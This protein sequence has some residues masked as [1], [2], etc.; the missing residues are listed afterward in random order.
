MCVTAKE[1]EFEKEGAV[2]RRTG[3]EVEKD[4][5]REVKVCVSMEGI[6]DLTKWHL[7]TLVATGIPLGLAEWAVCI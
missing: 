5:D 3:S 7:C 6:G 2:S 1:G 4:G